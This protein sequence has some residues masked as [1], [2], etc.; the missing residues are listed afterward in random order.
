[1]RRSRP[2]SPELEARHIAC[3]RPG[4]SIRTGLAPPDM[5]VRKRNGS[6]R[7]KKH[8]NRAHRSCL[9]ISHTLGLGTGP[10]LGTRKMMMAQ[11]SCQMQKINEYTKL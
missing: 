10:G 2:P 5:P 3:S 6:V 11:S 4:T 7:M 9:A 8:L 1:M